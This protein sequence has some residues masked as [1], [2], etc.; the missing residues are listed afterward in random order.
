MSRR[1]GA[2]RFG[3]LSSVLRPRGGADAPIQSLLYLAGL[4]S[5]LGP[6]SISIYTPSLVALR[7]SFNTS[8]ALAGAT[9]SVFSIVL[10]ASQLLYGPVVDRFSG[11]VVLA[12]GLVL[13]GAASLLAAWAP[14]IGVF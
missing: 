3:P 11:K 6:A 4:A 2:P 8:N 13:F 10:A 7:E 1:P 9:V 14:H 12:S 5:F